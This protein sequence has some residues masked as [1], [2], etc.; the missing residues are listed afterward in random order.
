MGLFGT[1][2]GALFGSRFG[3][4]GSLAG[5]T[6]GSYLEESFKKKG[7][8]SW[9]QKRMEQEARARMNARQEQKQAR[10]S[11]ARSSFQN[12]VLFL[13]AV[14]AMLAKLAK[15]DGRVDES[16]IAAGERAFERLGLTPEKRAFVIRAFRAA[17]LDGRT[18]F[19][20]AASFTAATPARAMRE[21]IY[22]ILWDLACA[23]G[24]LTLEERQI[25]EMITVSLG[26]R[27]SLFQ[28]EYQRRRGTFR[29][30]GSSRRGYREE[31]RR[32]S[33]ASDD[34]SSK[35]DPYWLLGCARTA[36]DDEVRR[37][38]RAQAKKYHPDLLR[39]QGLPEELVK[40]A[41]D[42]MVRIN[43]AWEEIKRAR[44]L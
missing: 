38:Y 29:E 30:G 5:A 16:E 43:A 8:E 40:R 35:G 33:S 20:Y 26:I 12:E 44:G 36:S 11:R 34:A 15:A 4:L 14:G 24:V 17:K 22:D 7:S 10:T 19:E 42:R 39:A 13:T 31:R 1:V 18:I 21:L 9:A 2:I 32:T 28:E 25:L 27:V 37:A 3:W 6:L 23:D 41:N